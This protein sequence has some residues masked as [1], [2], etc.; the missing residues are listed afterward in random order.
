MK[1]KSHFSQHLKHPEMNDVRLVSR[2]LVTKKSR[3][4]TIEFPA[5][6]M[7]S[8]TSPHLRSL[9]VWPFWGDVIFIEVLMGNKKAFKV[10]VL[11]LRNSFDV[12][13]CIKILSI[14]RRKHFQTFLCFCSS[15]S[16]NNTFTLGQISICFACG[17]HIFIKALLL[18]RQA[19]TWNMCFPQPRVMAGSGYSRWK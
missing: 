2:S 13:S 16:S 10:R 15:L 12:L 8:S 7:N 14:V 5:L 3:H 19:M 17:G 9:S 4:T 11:C 6:K 1:K 18:G